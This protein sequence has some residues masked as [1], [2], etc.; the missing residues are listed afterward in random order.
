MELYIPPCCID[1]KLPP[2]I[3]NGGSCTFFYSQGD[4]GLAKLWNAV[5][6]LVESSQFTFLSVEMLDVEILRFIRN[7]L[8]KG[9]IR[10]IAIVTS[11]D[12]TDIVK[13]ELSGLLDRVW[14]A[15]NVSA[16]THSNV[17]IRTSGT[18]SLVVSGPLSIKELGSG[19]F[20]A[21]SA[22]YH[23]VQQPEEL[24]DNTTMQSFRP[25]RSMLRLHATIKGKDY[26][27]EG[28]L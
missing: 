2:L 12:C 14:Y 18:R 26:A 17:W 4:W 9:W 20:S 24:Y 27:F 19:H 15:P 3:K 21:Y 8:D 22:H 23:L 28:W 13:D 1:K 7:Y 5:S 11:K 6:C 10:G 25:W 16:A